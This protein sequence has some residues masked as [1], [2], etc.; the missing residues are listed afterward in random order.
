MK[1]PASKAMV[2][3]SLMRIPLIVLMCS[4]MTIGCTHREP[5][6]SS[7]Q[8]MRGYELRTPL[9]GL[10]PHYR[11][12]DVGKAGVPVP[13]GDAA[14]WLLRVVTDSY[15][16]RRLDGLWFIPDSSDHRPL[17]VFHSDG[18]V[19]AAG[20]QII[21]EPCGLYVML[22]TAD[23][24]ATFRVPAG[25]TNVTCAKDPLTAA[26]TTAS[27]IPATD[28]NRRAHSLIETLEKNAKR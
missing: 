8:Y 17:I 18:P 20:Y 5:V 3:A 6:E 14:R 10:R 9:Y 25:S 1:L 2:Q 23:E 16:G 19:A 28:Y 21:G 11:V 24:Y 27:P 13:R 26:S 4:V 15:W 12:L 7:Q 22:S